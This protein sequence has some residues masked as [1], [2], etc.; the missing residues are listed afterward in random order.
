MRG[1][2]GHPSCIDPR[3]SN[4]FIAG[5][6]VLKLFVPFNP[7]FMLRCMH[8]EML[9]YVLLLAWTVDDVSLAFARSQSGIACT[10]ETIKGFNEMKMKKN[11]A[12]MIFK[13]DGAKINVSDSADTAT[14]EEFK[15]KI[16][17]FGTDCCYAVFDYKLKTDDGREINKLVFVS[18]VPDTAGVRKKMMY[19]S[20]LESF[21][22]T[23]STPF[24]VLQAS[25]IGELDEKNVKELIMKV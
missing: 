1:W 4:G 12:F 5:H 9:R 2:I 15:A 21:K 24:K 20:S 11:K 7:K 22:S 16:G 14:W 25:S 13:I 23:L 17:S 6:I 8:C 3:I 19:G 18:Y 10:E